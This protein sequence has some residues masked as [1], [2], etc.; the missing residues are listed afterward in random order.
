MSRHLLLRFECVTPAH[1]GSAAGEAMLDRPTQKDARDGL[2]FLPA[3]SLK[4]VLAGRL[5]D[6][7]DA[8]GASNAKREARYGSPDRGTERGR[9]APIVV[10]NGDLLCFP[11]P[12]SSGR[13]A[14]VFP[15]ATAAKLLRLSG[16][17]PG[18]AAA[19]R[20]ALV[21]LS[22]LEQEA[23]EP[24]AS[25]VALVHPAAAAA[26]LPPS[27]G[28]RPL[29]LGAA[30]GAPALLE[31]LRRLAGFSVE[32]GGGS[33]LVV[34]GQGVASRLWLHAA[35]RRTL[36]ALDGAT[37]TV[38]DA[39]LRTVE[40]IPAGTVFISRV[41]LLGDH[42]PELNPVQAGAWE[43]L[44][45]GWLRLSECGLDTETPGPRPTHDDGGRESGKPL[46][47]PRPADLIAGAFAAV[48]ALVGAEPRLRT[49]AR[50]AVYNFGP[51][52]RLDGLEAAV[53][54][55]LAKAKPAH[56]RP[57]A[58]TRAHR[59]LL[60]ALFDLGG[61]LHDQL[62][63]C[64]PLAAW[65]TDRHPFAG[66]GLAPRAPALFERWLWLRRYA[67]VNLTPPPPTPPTELMGPP[68]EGPG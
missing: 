17:E 58:E 61:E 25:G 12:W 60:G 52:A 35:E 22:R 3:S 42:R 55:S 49:A 15:A 23:N 47:R 54:F 20:D 19:T 13:P 18:E 59:W 29:D 16:G 14:Q 5:G 45:L 38:R 27:L 64:P 33:L 36:T 50:A 53:A 44:G 56:R 4:G 39:T 41:S 62:A 1:L 32:A 10:G 40:L 2:P 6:V 28:L 65:L 51:R 24:T 68:G 31:R 67:E 30:A 11:L 37:R 66:P 48:A 57:G 9:A 7:P 63:D 43:S 26:G 46:P 21:L 34:A 8:E